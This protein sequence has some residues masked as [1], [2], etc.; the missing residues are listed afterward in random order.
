[1]DRRAQRPGQ[2]YALPVPTIGVSLGL[3][4]PWATRLQQYRASIGDVTAYKIP[5]HITLVPP[6]HVPI[7]SLPTVHRHL[8]NVANGERSFPIRLK[9]TGTF[10]PISP[11][12][13]VA[14]AEGGTGCAE[15]SSTLRRGPLEI[16]LAFP[17]HPHVTVAHHLSEETMD[18]A[19]M[20]LADFECSF[21]CDA[22]SLYVLDPAKGWEAVREYR[23]EAPAPRVAM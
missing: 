22:F 10:R 21:G 6:T 14:L 19:Q 1:M 17:F 11:V 7:E 2:H 12:V 9:G 18:Q 4:E 8:L 23:L 16:P 13:F 5:T 3:P 15:L 20:E